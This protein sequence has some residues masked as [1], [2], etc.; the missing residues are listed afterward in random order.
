MSSTT[1][2]LVSIIIP[3]RNRAQYLERSLTSVVAAIEHYPNTEL[4]VIDGASTDG[5]VDI[6]KKYDAKISYWVSEPDSGLGEAVNKGFAKSRGEIILFFGDDDELLPHSIEFMV[7]Y[8]REHPEVDAAFGTAENFW[9][10][11]DGRIVQYPLPYQL[12]R[13][14]L[15]RLLRV[16]QDGWPTAEMQF[17]RRRLYERFGTFDMH[18]RYIGSFET[19]CRQVKAGAFLEQL[20]E[21]VARRYYT[22]DSGNVRA[23]AELSREFYEVLKQFGGRR[24]VISSKVDALRTAASPKIVSLWRNRLWFPLLGLTRPVRRAVGLDHRRMKEFKGKILSATSREAGT[25]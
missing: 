24:A 15:K 8:L 21:I 25:K 13:L 18:Y 2:P 3:T 10:L 19:W 1:N 22:P 20:P 12:G 23:S 4:I 14:T 17:S 6:L 11:P 7:R 5:A 9:Y 16:T